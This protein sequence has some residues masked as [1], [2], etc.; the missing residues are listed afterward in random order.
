M[1]VMLPM[2]WIFDLFN[3]I[4]HLQVCMI[5]LCCVVQ[6]SSGSASGG[7]RVG[8]EQVIT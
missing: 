7:G 2:M 4:Y 8:P 6:G 1:Y 3:I 5:V